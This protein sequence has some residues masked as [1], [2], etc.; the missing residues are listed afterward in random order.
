ME[1]SFK[2]QIEGDYLAVVMFPEEQPQ[3]DDTVLKQ[4]F[5]LNT[6]NLEKVEAIDNYSLPYG[7]ISYKSSK[8]LQ[9]GGL[10]LVIDYNH[11]HILL[12]GLTRQ[13]NR[14]ETDNYYTEYTFRMLG[15]QQTSEP[16]S[17]PATRRVRKSRNPVDT[18]NDYTG[19]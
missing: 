16:I 13:G 9:R 6:L 2:C 17:N 5:K 4:K 11:D 18:T 19:T 8:S 7:R 15:V 10:E 1:Y 12:F 14:I 3:T